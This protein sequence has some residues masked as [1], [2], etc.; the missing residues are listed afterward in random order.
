MPTVVF[1]DVVGSTGLFEQ[2][3]DTNA[4][5]L[6]NRLTNLLGKVFEQHQGRVVKLLGDGV[7]AVF[8]DAGNAISACVTLQTRFKTDPVI[9]GPDT[10][11]IRMQM[12]VESGELVEIDGDCFGDAVNSASR[13]A[14][15]AGA[16]QILTTQHVWDGLVSAHRAML[17][18]LG[19]MHLRGKV[20]ASHVYRVEWQSDRD[21]DATAMG[22]S[23]Y[24]P[25]PQQTLSL[26]VQ[27]RTQ[28][29]PL[30]AG[31]ITIG[32]STDASLPVLDPRVSRVHATICSRGGQIVLADASS[33][34][35]WVY[36]GNQSEAVAL[37]RTECFLVGFGQLSLGCQIHADKPPLVAFEVS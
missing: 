26:T 15:L 19:P 17:R 2:L 18:S 31:G 8:P 28:I 13:L 29:F 6:M 1:A 25:N 37:R 7:F 32:R 16:D 34:G 4:S 12:G 36:F 21:L 11:P 33:F 24:T 20:H 22:M 30:T 14:D 5:L 35:T 27:G 10:P 9:P 23:M 3:G